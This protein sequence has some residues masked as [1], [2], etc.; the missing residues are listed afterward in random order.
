MITINL[1]QPK[2]SEFAFGVQLALRKPAGGMG[3]SAAGHAGY[4][5]AIQV[6][7]TIVKSTVSPFTDDTVLVSFFFVLYCC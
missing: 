4:E 5:R 7:D 2:H 3:D 6:L 1:I